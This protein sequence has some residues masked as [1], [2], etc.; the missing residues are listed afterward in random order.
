MSEPS[1]EN[2][3][4]VA[5]KERDKL[6]RELD[7]AKQQ[8]AEATQ[9]EINLRSDWI[10]ARAEIKDYEIALV[11]LMHRHDWHPELGQCVCFEHKQ[12][13]ETLNKWSG[14]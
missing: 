10:E 3:L 13:R 9:R 14:K 7:E 1:L 11:N 8:L 6:Q 12:A 2:D 4:T 5:I